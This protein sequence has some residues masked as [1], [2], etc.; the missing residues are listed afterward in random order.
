MNITMIK[1]TIFGLVLSLSGFAS[2]GLIQYSDWHD[3]SGDGGLRQAYF[4]DAVYFAVAKDIDYSNLDTYVAPNGFRI[5]TQNDYFTLWNSPANKTNCPTECNFLYFD[6]GD[7]NGYAHNGT[8]DGSLFAFADKQVNGDALAANAGNY[9]THAAQKS[10]NAYYG[11]H[12]LL[13]PHIFGGMILIKET[14]TVPEPSTLAIFALG[15]IG[16]ASRRFK[17][18]S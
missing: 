18:Q 11:S 14:K 15:M 3:N 1:A 8:T 7:W 2:A 5:A 17:K 16:L 13:N 4:H 9:E 6:Q 12:L 10:V